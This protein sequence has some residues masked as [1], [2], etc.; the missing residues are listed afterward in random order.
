M[1]TPQPI[2]DDQR[3]TF[4]A[5]TSGDFTN[6]ALISTLFDG[7]PTVAI[8]AIV[9]E[10]GTYIIQPLYVAV[11]DTMFDRLTDPAAGLEEEA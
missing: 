7:E 2:S 3:E 1:T 6:F 4:D 8:A 9:E 10:G 5:L 11:T